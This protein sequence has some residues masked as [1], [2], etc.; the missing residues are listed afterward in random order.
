MAFEVPSL[1]TGAARPAAPTRAIRRRDA[2][3]I[4]A[5]GAGCALLAFAAAGA[6][7][8]KY[9]SS[10]EVSVG[11]PPASGEANAEFVEH[12]ARIAVSREVL[13]RVVEGE[14]LEL[15]PEFV[16]AVF[17]WTAAARAAGLDEDSATRALAAELSARPA[18]RP[19]ALEI[20]VSDRDPARAAALA[21]AAARA[22]VAEAA[23][24]RASAAR[25]AG[26]DMAGRLEALRARAAAAEKR[27]EDYKAA[28]NLAEALDGP[29]FE[30]RVKDLDDEIAD[31]RARSAS[32]RDAVEQIEIARKT[33]AG[34][35]ASAVDPATLGPALARQA[36]ARQQFAAVNAELGPRHPRVIDAR[37]RLR[38]ADDAAGIELERAAKGRRAEFASAKAREADLTRQLADLQRQSA[39][40]AEPVM[41]LRDL[42]RQ[43]AAARQ[44]YELLVAPS[45]DA[46]PAPEAGAKGAEILTPAE[47]P[48]T[49]KFPPSP[50]ASSG[51]G[52]LFGLGLGFLGAARRGRAAAAA[53]PRAAG[54]AV[55]PSG[56]PRLTVSAAAAAPARARRQSLDRLDLTGLGFG[57]PGEDSDT[58][59]FE[60]V[61]DAAGF[62]PPRPRSRRRQ[63]LALAV[64]GSNETGART[65]LAIHLAIAAS[66]LDASVVLLDAAGR[67]A[68]LTRAVREAARAPVLDEASIYPTENGPRL[69]LPKAFDPEWGRLRPEAMLRRLL[70]DGDEPA[71]LIICDGP[72]PGELDAESVFALVDAIVALDEEK[73][74]SALEDLGFAPDVLVRLETRERPRRGAVLGFGVDVPDDEE[75]PAARPRSRSTRGRD[76]GYDEAPRRPAAAAAPLAAKKAARRPWR[77]D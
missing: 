27:V 21:N 31:E 9:T 18:G 6:S 3:L 10:A 56:P 51:L 57:A 63:P 54:R 70:D 20:S 72:D 28:N 26:A 75:S 58:R 53:P 39:P 69:A 68:K 59:E 2:G 12:Q 19:A 17:G 33:G 66:G 14:N 22:Y 38:A 42:E 16:P 43:A 45:R 61:L 24:T 5:T 41:G 30:A 15:D 8:P 50:P 11:A 77:Q 44:R 23:T 71:D 67:N 52:L 25:Q 34:L 60:A 47:I 40:D 36:E 1:E 13:K 55:E 74:L 35:A 65:A 4:A 73:A 29:G 48:M 76:G 32:A 7:A 62:A 64:V 46:G 49:R 37:A